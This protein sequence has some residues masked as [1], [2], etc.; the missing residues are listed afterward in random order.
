[1]ISEDSENISTF[2]PIFFSRR[3]RVFSAYPNHFPY[4]RGWFTHVHPGPICAA[5]FWVPKK[6]RYV[7]CGMA[8]GDVRVWGATNVGGFPAWSGC[9]RTHVVFPPGSN[10]RGKAGTQAWGSYSPV[11]W[12]K[13]IHFC[14]ETVKKREEKGRDPKIEDFPFVILGRALVGG[15]G[16][17]TLPYLT[18]PD[19]SQVMGRRMIIWCHWMRY[20]IVWYGMVCYRKRNRWKGLFSDGQEPRSVFLYVSNAIN[21]LRKPPRLSILAISFAHVFF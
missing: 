5:K 11:S 8:N 9:R 3:S 20:G 16:G 2:F 10:W 15:F 14:G 17:F 7:I 21:W 4:D 13:K 12:Q 18:L 6:L 1:M 19:S